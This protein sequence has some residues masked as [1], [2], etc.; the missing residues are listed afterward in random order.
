MRG[1]KKK[2]RGRTAIEP[3]LIRKIK[4]KIDLV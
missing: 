2:Q 4:V 3:F 1:F